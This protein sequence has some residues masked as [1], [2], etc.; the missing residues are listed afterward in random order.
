MTDLAQSKQSTTWELVDRPMVN[1]SYGV[2]SMTY[3][4][5][6]MFE[7]ARR[8]GASGKP[9]YVLEKFV[10]NNEYCCVSSSPNIDD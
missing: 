1:T 7:M 5:W 9:H 10:G 6:C 4:Q 8:A 3:R 2:T